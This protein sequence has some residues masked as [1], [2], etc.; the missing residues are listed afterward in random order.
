MYYVVYLRIEGMAIAAEM[1]VAF[2][3]I[4]GHR[5]RLISSVLYEICT[6]MHDST[7]LGG[8]KA[9]ALAIHWWTLYLCTGSSCMQMSSQL[10]TVLIARVEDSAEAWAVKMGKL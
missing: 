9:S 3:N 6:F 2:E 1:Q 4:S 7:P 10:V 5:I 8:E